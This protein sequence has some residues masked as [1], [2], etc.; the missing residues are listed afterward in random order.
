[1]AGWLS[2]PGHCANLMNPRYTEMGAAY[3]LNSARK[4]TYPYW[5]QVFGAPR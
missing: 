2:S 1:V 3:G 4:S 5:T